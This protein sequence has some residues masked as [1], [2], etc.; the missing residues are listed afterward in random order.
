MTRSLLG[1]ALLLA[2][3]AGPADAEPLS[4]AQAVQVALHANPQVQ[5]S[6]EDLA[7]FRGRKREA[8]ADALPELTLLG[9][10][11][12]YRDPALL[13]SSSFD[14]FPPEL[15]SALRPVP[16]NLY[17]GVARLHQT[18]FTF[19]VG[20][21][22]KAAG[23]AMTLGDEQLRRARQAVAL[24]AISA[25]DGYLLALEQV[26][27]AE[28]SVRQ[29]ERHLETARN[30][31]AA[32]VATD[33]E[34]L[35]TR[36]D[37][38]NQRA[39]LLRFRGQADLARSALNAVMLRP[40]DSAV[41]PTD[42]LD[43][44]PLEVGLDEA[45]REAWENR[46]EARAASLSEKIYDELVGVARAEGRPRLDFDAVW[47]YSVRQPRNFFES[48]F[49]KWSATVTLTVPV[50]DGFRTAGKVAQARADRAKVT[51]DR[52]ALQNQIRLE[53]KGAVDRLAVARSILEAAALNVAQ[54]QKALEMTQ[55]NYQYG[56]AT[57][58]DVLDAQAALVQ[59]ESNRI[60]ALYE[61][62]SARAQ[63]RY[64][65]ARDPLDPTP[66]QAGRADP[67]GDP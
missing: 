67:G 36:V 55:A 35:R 5:K 27:V 53:A 43:F 57:T 15:R 11:T 23:L 46:P 21:A 25:Y 60:L 17:E 18:L 3:A 54:A 16:A 65:M 50:F 20:R 63:L 37:V 4:R 61:H 66:T 34:V 22:V 6:L 40:I 45:V 52:L 9:S 12:R 1:V 48:D 41:E 33:L 62:A 2:G 59:A 10:A 7:M 26:Q 30:R 44:V 29:K 56:A 58:L 24:E 49:T 31:R 13:N 32:G 51:Q 19:K 39:I 28:K 42:R 8:L 14:S 38:E 64:V 47:G